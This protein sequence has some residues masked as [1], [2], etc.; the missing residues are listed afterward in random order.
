MATNRNE[1]LS[2]VL[3][4]HDINKLDSLDKFIAKKNSVKASISS[5]YSGEKA[6]NPVDSGSYAKGTAINT[7]FDIDLCIPFRKKT[8][9]NENGFESLQEMY[10]SLY[11]YLRNEY[12][13]EDDELE[14][15]DVRKQKVSIG[16]KFNIDSDSL[17]IDVV[18][19][20]ERPDHGDYNDNNTDLSLFIHPPS[21][22]KKEQEEGKVRIKTNIKKHID[23]LGGVS[24][25]HERKI[26]RILKVWKTE[27]KNQDGGKLIKSF[28]ME[29]YTKEA[30]DK[31]Q[32]EIPTGLWEKTKMVMNYIIENIEEHALVDPANSDNVVSDSMSDAAKSNTRRNMQK[33]IR[34]IDE[35]SD[36]IKVHFPINED[37][38]NEDDSGKNATLGASVLST[39]KFG[40]SY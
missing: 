7:K 38:N 27:R 5:K 12:A 10:D 21:R 24:R 13:E 14:K 18:P 34:E 2:K 15:E 4:T 37:Y 8:A 1:H 3:E 6:S 35:D 9:E 31:H 23:L 36:K 30:F 20:R 33:T 16:L 32:D 28:I 17:E 29:L 19:G 25:T 39:S 22:S 40:R 11:D 26:A